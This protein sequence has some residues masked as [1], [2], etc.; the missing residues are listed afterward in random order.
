LVGRAANKAVLAN[1]FGP[2]I[3]DFLQEQNGFPFYRL[4]IEQKL[5]TGVPFTYDGHFY[6][7]G[8]AVRNKSSLLSLSE[9]VNEVL[10]GKRLF[11]EFSKSG[12]VTDTAA[13]A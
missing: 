8:F 1:M 7:K 13:P 6:G 3:S 11:I 2:T 4:A 12:L 5:R 9:D 10:P